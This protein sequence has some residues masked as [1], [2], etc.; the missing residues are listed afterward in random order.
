M[1]YVTPVTDRTYADLVAL[2]SK[3]YMNV[4]DWAR[5]YGNSRLVNSLAAIEL[6]TG[7]QFNI[8]SIPTTTTIPSATDVNTLAGNIE[9]ARLA[10]VGESIPGTSTEIKD[11]YIAGAGEMAPKY[12][13]VN[14][15]ES[16]L[17]AIWEYYNG[18]DL[19]VCP[20]LSADLTILTGAQEI[21][22]DCIN[23]GNFEIIIQGTGELHII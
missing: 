14:L 22:V 9:R 18:P 7:I 5:I 16:T 23:P 4:V 15:W 10:V 2:N 1:S 17:D 12:T 8:L 13:D 21:Y 20:T 11:D 19:D 6:A 3:A